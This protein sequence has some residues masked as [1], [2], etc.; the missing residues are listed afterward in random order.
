M[1]RLFDRLLAEGYQMAGGGLERLYD[2]FKA[3]LETATVVTAD[4]V[5][6]Y[7]A[8]HRPEGDT[9]EEMF[10]WLVP[11]LRSLFIETRRAQSGPGKGLEAWGGLFVTHDLTKGDYV[12]EHEFYQASP[13][14]V[15]RGMRTE[16]RW[17]VHVILFVREKLGTNRVWQFSSMPLSSDGR[18]CLSEANRISGSCFMGLPTAVQRE[19]LGQVR[20][21][22]DTGTRLLMPLYLALSFMHCRNVAL[23]EEAP[24]PP[25]DKKWRKKHDRPLV[26]YH[27]L[28]IDPMREVLRN[29]G[30]SDEVGLRKAL[31]ICR[32]HF[33]T[34]TPEKPLFGRLTGTFWRPQHVRG[35]IKNGAVVKDYNVKAP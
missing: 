26:R 22:L 20:E 35:S 12:L 5:T 11:P 13:R 2:P 7:Y 21:W 14:P 25:L 15:N 8:E 3:D 27:V 32:G 17:V 28:N 23:T 33:A 9:I 31:H 1:A 30:R 18:Y 4:N 19:H 34:Y 10:P 29:E 24:P 6:A 16:A